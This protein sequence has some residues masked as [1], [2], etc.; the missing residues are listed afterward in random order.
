MELTHLLQKGKVV[1]NDTSISIVDFGVIGFYALFL[2]SLG[3]IFKKFSHNSS[4]FFRGGGRLQWWMCGASAFMVTFSAWTFTGAAGKIYTTG[5]LVLGLYY[6]NVIGFILSYFFTCYRI[7]QLRVVTYAEAI[8]NRYGR[9]NEQFYA[10]TQ[11]PVSVVFG[12]IWLNAVSIFVSSVFGL[13]LT[14]T[15]LVV[16]TIVIFNSVL[17]GAWAVVASDFV[18]MLVVVTITIVAA[19]LALMH[20]AV[21]GVSGLLEQAPSHHFNW[22]ELARPEIIVLWI[23]ALVITQSS[24]INNMAEGGSRYLMVRDSQHARKAVLIPLF[25]MLVF[26]V[27]W[28]IP[29]MAAT[30]TNPNI[31]ADFPNLVRPEEAAYVAISLQ[32]MPDGLLGLLICGI[33]AATLSSMDSGLNRSAGIVLRNLYK[34]LFKPNA[35]EDHL[36]TAGRVATFCLGIVMVT[37]ALAM[38]KF[39]TTDLF[40]VVVNFLGAFSLPLAIPMLYGLF[41]RRVPS[42]A[43]WSTALIGLCLGLFFKFAKPDLSFVGEWF[44][45]SRE[46]NARELGDASYFVTVFTVFI[47]CTSWYFLTSLFFGRSTE[48]FKKQVQDF[49][50][51][52]NKPVDH[53]EEDIGKTDTSQFRTIGIICYIYGSF[54]CLLM[55]V[56]NPIQGRLS[57]LFCGGFVLLIGK[58]LKTAAHRIDLNESVRQKDTSNS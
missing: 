51:Q 34:P 45:F 58:L 38:S 14:Q 8:R 39:R 49:F 2:A 53:E 25:C 4:D 22:S 11:V 33:F 5:A 36:L 28:I 26:P 16:G 27:I 54:I 35:S 31:A 23:S 3:I 37:A 15:I 9:A 47:V 55:L 18:Q 1:L 48:K 57:F 13:G 24:L 50:T 17:G 29:S 20:P 46:M 12:A 42:W 41:Y 30:I 40:G 56:P 44:S 10:W 32:T 7:R 19:V 6:A 21:G 43:G 52:V